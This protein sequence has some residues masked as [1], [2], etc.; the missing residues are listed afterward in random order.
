MAP[1]DQ[2]GPQEGNAPGPGAGEPLGATLGA[3][4]TGVA[5]LND[6]GAV[7]T[8]VEDEVSPSLNGHTPASTP[9]PDDDGARMTL[10]EHLAELR[11]R[12]LYCAIAIVVTSIAGW[13]LYNPV[14]HFMTEPYRAFYHSHKHLVT[15]D[16]VISSP[17]E[18]FTTRLKVSMYIGLALAAPVWLWQVWQFVTPGLK[19]NEKRY[20]VPFVLSSLLLFSMGVVTAILVWPKALNWLISAS[21]NG[22]A[23]LFT[24]AGYVSLYVLICL[25]FGGVF[26]YPIV[27]V[28]LM[29]ARVVPSTK[30]RKWRRPAIVALCAVAAVVTPSNDP[31]TFLGMAVPMLLFYEISI[32]IGRLLKR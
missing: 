13:F 1:G 14:L 29:I 11:R 31:F 6:G 2:D 15:P 10:W 24:P 8:A 4:V 18:G 19:Q 16:L 28:F 21:G 23:P 17:T 3:D 25:V 5:G 9:E 7:S 12:V 20:A 22:V 30:W 27:V 26:L 32:I